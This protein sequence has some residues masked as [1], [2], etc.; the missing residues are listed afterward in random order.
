MTGGD[1]REPSCL[2]SGAPDVADDLA[3]TVE[4]TPGEEGPVGPMPEAA[5]DHRDHDVAHHL[6]LRA[7][8]ASE[9]DVEVVPQPARQGDV[10]P[11]PEVLKV[12]GGVRPVEVD[13]EL[14]P[15]QE[16]KADGDVGVPGEVAVDLNGVAPDAEE[17]VER[18][19]AR[20][21]GEDR[22]DDGRRDEG[23]D[24]DLLEQPP[25]DELGRPGVVDVLPVV[26]ATNLREQLATSNDGAG[27]QVREER[28][29]DRHVDRARWLELPA[30]VVHHVAD[31]HEREERDGDRERRLDQ[32]D[33]VAQPHRP[34]DV[35]DVDG[36]EA[37]VFEIGEDADQDDD[38]HHHG[39]ATTTIGLR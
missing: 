32:R 34:S 17:C 39:I 35:V 7:P 6:G 19:V 4:E 5:E 21:G 29:V 36:H 8:V 30:I 13:G 26:A 25:H 20:R 37:H 22:I 24:H 18:R 11:A 33:Q 12:D 1:G 3:C 23:A 15:Q 10:P 14:D 31:S 27:D 2:A 9:R 28:E 16:R 38:R